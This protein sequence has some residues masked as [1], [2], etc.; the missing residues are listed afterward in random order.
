MDKMSEKFTKQYN[1]LS[2]NDQNIIKNQVSMILLQKGFSE[3]LDQVSLQL[4]NMNSTI[5][6]EIINTQ[7]ISMYSYAIEKINYVSISYLRTS[8]GK[9][10]NILDDW[11]LYRFH[12]EAFDGLE[13]SIGETNYRYYF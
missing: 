13:N 10:N 12:D 6:Q 5:I 3:K 4:Q 11:R 8:R 9:M 1:E 2:Q 7:I